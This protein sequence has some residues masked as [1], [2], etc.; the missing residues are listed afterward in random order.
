[1]KRLFAVLMSA[2]ILA[3]S[4]NPV[5]AEEMM[6]AEVTGAEYAEESENDETAAMQE[7]ETDEK[8]DE[9]QDVQNIPESSQEAAYGESE[10]SVSSE[11]RNDEKKEEEVLTQTAQKVSTESIPEYSDAASDTENKP[12]E[13]KPVFNDNEGKYS[14]GISQERISFGKVVV[15]HPVDAQSVYITNTGNKAVNLIWKDID[16]DCAFVVDTT[17]AVLI[18]PGQTV[19]VG[20][21]IATNKGTGKYNGVLLFADASDTAYTSGVKLETSVTITEDKAV[22]KRVTIY[23]SETS[24]A[25]GSG[26]DFQAEVEGEGEFDK[27]AEYKLNGNKSTDTYIDSNGHLNIA[28]NESASELIVRASAVGDNSQYKEARVHIKQNMYTVNVYSTPGRAGDVTGSGAYQA[29]SSVLVKAYAYNGWYLHGW[30]VNGKFVAA[31]NTYQIDNIRENYNVEAL[32]ERDSVRIKAKPN[33]SSMGT[34]EGD[35]FAEIGDNVVLKATPKKGYRFSCWMEGKKKISSDSKLKLKDVDEDRELTAVFAKDECAVVVASC[36]ETMGKVSGGKT[37]KYGKDVTIKANPNKGYRFVKWVCND[38]EV[39]KKAECKLPEIKDDIT[40]VAI[41]EPEK[42]EK[43]IYKMT[44]GTTDSNGVISPSGIIDMEQGKSINYTITPKSGYYIAAIAVDGK[45]MAVSSSLTISNITSDH[46]I[47]AAFLPIEKSTAAAP[48]D[49]SGVKN[50]DTG[51]TKQD[52]SSAEAEKSDIHKE[53][54]LAPMKQYDENIINADIDTDTYVGDEADSMNNELDDNEGVLQEINMSKAEANKNLGDDAFKYDLIKQA[55]ALESLGINIDND[56]RRNK[57]VMS[58]DENALDNPE[59]V[60]FAKILCGVFDDDEVMKLVS[61][62]EKVFVDVAVTGVQEENV[63]MGQ[64]SKIKESMPEGKKAAQYFF[65]DFVKNVDGNAVEIKE[66]STPIM[67]T[68]DIP[69]SVYKSGRDYT[70]ARLHDGE[71]GYEFTELVDIDDNPRTVTFETDRFSTYAILCD[72]DLA[73]DTNAPI[74]RP[75]IVRQKHVD[76][77]V[78][79]IAGAMV[80]V[81]GVAI[82]TVQT[83]GRRKRRR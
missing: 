38:N 6:E 35:G 16:P 51:S 19:P 3:T 76:W 77:V 33:H 1:M 9:Q 78:V 45:P 42:S 15:G 39:S 4:V 82:V 27:R 29:G 57:F 70:I 8:R 24:A 81:F 23:P 32:F 13:L 52:G 49:N 41:F 11:E 7:A 43:K 55:I 26:V 37:V 12:E 75:V 25:A 56:M 22:I 66:F 44:S 59:T 80:V 62:E 28:S 48:K 71:N 54:N 53:V 36:D 20:I 50:A 2:A 67:V 40:L 5:M 21:S 64:L 61:G 18:Q 14:L 83:S 47:V 73:V 10:Q 74:A 17:K 65:S 60:N 79:G 69:E 68:V 46:T 30:Q 72:S 31:G 58:Y 63:P 34:V